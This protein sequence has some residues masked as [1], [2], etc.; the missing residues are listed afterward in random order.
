ML[1]T[2]FAFLIF[3][4]NTNVFNVSLKRGCFFQY[5]VQSVTTT[6]NPNNPIF[7]CFLAIT[8]SFVDS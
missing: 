1:G 5:L 7:N 2:Y 4:L 8:A 3:I 6:P